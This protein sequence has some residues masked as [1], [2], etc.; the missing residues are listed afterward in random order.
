MPNRF[1]ILLKTGKVPVSTMMRRLLTG[2]ALFFNGK[3]RRKGR[4]FQ[5]R[6]KS[7][8]CL[9]QTYLLELVRYIHL[10]PLQAGIVPDLKALDK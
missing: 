9:E 8:L 7:I 5:N 10:N 6:Y 4:L 2:Y 3:H 1:N